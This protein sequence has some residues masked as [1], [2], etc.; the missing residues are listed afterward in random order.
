M[1]ALTGKIAVI[2]G[3]TS[4]IGVDIARS[5]VAEGARVVLAGRRKVQGE[6]VAGSLGTA[7]E[8][9]E[10]DVAV[11]AEVAALIATAIDRHG[12]VDVVVNNAGAPANLGRI[13]DVDIEAFRRVHDVNLYGPLFAI[14]HVAAH[15]TSRGSGSIINLGSVA[16]NR[17]GVTGLDYSTSK[18]ALH[19]LT[20]W[21]AIELGEHGVRVNTVSPGF[22][23]TGIFAKAGG[24]SDAEAERSIA[25]LAARIRPHLARIQPISVPGTGADVAAAAVFLA[26]DAARYING[27]DLA[28]DGGMAVGQPYSI[29]VEQRAR[30]AEIV[31]S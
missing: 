15:M 28:L 6:A 1:S 23:A 13:A 7:A 4:G 18:A 19:H 30:I 27:H 17:A 9:V 11:E 21:A 10:T 5:F 14:K 8:F 3:A 16:G 26:S 31:T 25:E 22:V 20:R 24:Q 29:L 12:A 2:T